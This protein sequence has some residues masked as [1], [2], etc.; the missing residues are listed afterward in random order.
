MAEKRIRRQYTEQEFAAK[1]KEAGGRS[2]LVGG[3]VRDYC[4]GAAAKDRDYVICGLNRPDFER[5]FP[6]AHCVG[7]SF[8]VYLLDIDGETCE[9]SLARRERKIADGYRGFAVSSDAQITIEQD[10]WRRD[11]RMNAMAL[12][13]PE[14]TLVDPYDG[15][16]DIREGVIRPV[17]EHFTEDPVRALRAAR[18]AAELGYALP[19][20]TLEM[21]SRCRRELQKESEERFRKELERA[22]AAARPSRFFRALRQAGLLDITF[23]EIFAL[24]G[25]T[26]PPQWHPE[27]D[28]FEHTMQV[29]DEVS[30]EAKNIV[31]RFAALV[32]DLGKG[33]T[34]PEMLPHHYDHE[35]RGLEVLE[36]WR[37]RANLP[38]Q[39]LE[40]A[41]FVIEHHMHACRMKK[42]GKIVKLLLALKR[43]PLTAEEFCIILRAD[44]S[45]PTPYLLY[46][47]E[48][49]PALQAVSGRDAPEGLQGEAVGV[50]IEGQRTRIYRRLAAELQGIETKEDD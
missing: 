17:S 32:H 18:Q 33:T 38:K 14:R 23:P 26:Q 2:F 24:I 4:R 36:K 25:K 29:V 5:I 30:A 7:K 34:P 20:E 45:E 48:L 39:W 27:G 28:A 41:R 15:Q 9:V 16:A 3:Y 10:L 42:P 8:P 50:W 1:I 35:T 37:T 11:T 46:A 40:A 22:L 47:D 44:H 21:M 6:G 13:L 12:E 31:C 19:R 43:C 49:L